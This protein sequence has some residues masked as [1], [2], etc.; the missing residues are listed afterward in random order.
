MRAQGQAT[1]APTCL[2]NQIAHHSFEQQTLLGAEQ[3]IH[4]LCFFT[5]SPDPNSVLFASYIRCCVTSLN[6]IF[7]SVQGAVEASGG[8][9]CSYVVTNFDKTALT[10]VESG[11]WKLW[12]YIVAIYMMTIMTL[13]VCPPCPHAL[14]EHSCALWQT[15]T[16]PPVAVLVLERACF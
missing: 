5:K 7:V 8:D 2:S 6:T 3:N 13:Y 14:S 10:N 9:S 1:C 15:L 11:H 16:S 4:L 12:I